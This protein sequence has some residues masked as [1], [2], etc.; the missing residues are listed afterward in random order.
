LIGPIFFSLDISS[1]RIQLI[2]SSDEFQNLE[3]G[4]MTAV[5]GLRASNAAA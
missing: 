4:Q 1:E 5:L 3:S 2:T